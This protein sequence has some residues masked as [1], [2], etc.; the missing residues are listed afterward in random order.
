[1]KNSKRIIALVLAA[2]ALCSMSM[3]AFATEETTAEAT[4]VEATTAEATTAETT[5]A[6]P[7]SAE[8]TTTVKTEIYVTGGDLIARENYLEDTAKEDKN[9][10]G[11]EDTYTDADGK[12]WMYVN[13]KNYIV[14]SDDSAYLYRELEDGTIAVI[15]N[16]AAEKFNGEAEIPSSLDGKTVSKVDAYAFYFQNKVSAIRVPDS[17]KEIAYYAFAYC[18]GIKRIVF[19]NG[20]E[21]VSLQAF[22]GIN[23]AFEIYFCCTEAQADTIVVWDSKNTN[24]RTCFNWQRV[25]GK[26]PV[27]FEADADN[28][29]EIKGELNLIEWFWNHFK[30]YV[31]MFWEYNKGLFEETISVLKNWFGIEDK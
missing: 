14:S 13:G 12:T 4:T 16:P 5:T 24:A 8:E 20:L 1:M 7:T 19:G 30:E 25:N 26:A 2:L 18:T 22:N 29:D 10:D 11:D 23:A 9:W 27:Y 15:Y 6:E 28:L 31:I 17:V 21:S 3:S